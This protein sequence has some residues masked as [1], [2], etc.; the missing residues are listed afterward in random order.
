MDF[1]SLQLETSLE[2]EPFDINHVFLF[3][4]LP[5]REGGQLET[6]AEPAAPAMPK[7]A[8]PA[9]A[10]Q[11]YSQ[12]VPAPRRASVLALGDELSR[13]GD[14]LSDKI[15][16]FLQ[17]IPQLV[18][19]DEQ[20]KSTGTKDGKPNKGQILTKGVEFI[21]QLQAAIDDSNRREVDL[22]RRVK[23]LEATKQLPA[24]E[25]RSDFSHTTAERCLADIGVGPLADGSPAAPSVQLGGTPH[26]RRPLQ[27][28]MSALNTPVLAEALPGQAFPM[29][30]AL[31][32]NAPNLER[33]HLIDEQLSM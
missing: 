24:G 19:Q 17:L 28:G 25:Q 29:Q 18:F 14:H 33:V 5:R 32:G 7:V 31:L 9:G 2:G 12:S 8:E 16:E 3:P 30:R 22:Q 10:K 23:Q 27:S 15:Q 4:E 26:Y 21:L 11:E 20:L 1:A 13:K 6:K